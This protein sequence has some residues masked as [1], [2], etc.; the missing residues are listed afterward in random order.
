MSL[1][2][3]PKSILHQNE[4]QSTYDTNTNKF[5]AFVRDNSKHSSAVKYVVYLYHK[6]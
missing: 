4:K 5:K 3:E 2:L 1:I 6:K